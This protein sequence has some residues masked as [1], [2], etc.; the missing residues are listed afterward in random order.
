MGIIS[1]ALR[2]PSQ[3]TQL[4]ATLVGLITLIL[5][6]LVSCIYVIFFTESSLIV[7][8]MSGIGEVAILLLLLGNLAGTYQQ[9]FFMMRALGLFDENGKIIKPEEAKMEY[10]G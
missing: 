8:I 2:K 10:V 1:K 3:R 7:K 9:Y 5:V 6:S 4:E